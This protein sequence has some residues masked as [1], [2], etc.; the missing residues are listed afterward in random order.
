MNYLDAWERLGGL[1]YEDLPEDVRRVALHCILDWTGCALA[2]SREPL[3]ELLRAEYGQRAG[4]CHVIGGDRQT[5]AETAALLNGASGHA[6][7]YDDTNPAVGCHATAPVLPAA[8]AAAQMRGASGAD[9][10]TAFVVGVEIEGRVGRAIGTEHYN[11]GW[12]TTATFG[13][14]G[15]A[16]AVSRLLG[17]DSAQ[18]AVAMGLAASRASGVKA[19]FGTMTKPYHAGL[20]AAAGL[21]SAQLVA[22]GF[23]AN[24][25]A[26]FGNQGYLQAAATGRAYDERVHAVAD[27]WLI[28]ETLFK[29]HA[30]CHLTH[31]AIEGVC[32]LRHAAPASRVKGITLSVHP[33]ILDVCG[34]P[35]PTTGLQGKFSLRCTAA[36]A[37]LGIDTANPQVFVDAVIRREDVQRTLRRVTVEADASL[38]TMQTRVTMTCTDGEVCEAWHDTNMPER[39]LDRQERH[40]LAKFE[41]LT[42]DARR[43]EAILGLGAEARATL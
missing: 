22:R 1:T 2:G 30:A 9:L 21:T 8:L 32:A 41:S 13:V 17:L 16:A 3:A 25:D 36:M 26:V 7:D 28:A 11:R 10:I 31:A 23:T 20:A 35:E 24:P 14:F 40:L 42:G 37:L 43:G 34:I 12:H 5:D 33:D 19:N 39:D 6:L 4:G 18:Y 15:A 38:T 29:H 27:R